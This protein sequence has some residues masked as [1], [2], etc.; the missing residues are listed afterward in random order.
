MN[1]EEFTQQRPE[2]TLE[3]N[4]LVATFEFPRFLAAIAVIN[5]VAVAAEELQHHP[6][7][8]HNFTTVTFRLSTHDDGNTVTEKDMILA[9]KIS[10]IVALSRKQNDE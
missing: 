6:S 1:P 4:Q 9:E 3:H 7:Y 2:W 10:A 8:T 5:A